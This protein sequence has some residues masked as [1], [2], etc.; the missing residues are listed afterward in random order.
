MDD[1]PHDVQPKP[2]F[3]TVRERG[4][5]VRFI[6]AFAPT[7]GLIVLVAISALWAALFTAGLLA[8]GLGVTALGVGSWIGETER[9]YTTPTHRAVIKLLI[10]LALPVT[11]AA[12][13]TQSETTGYVAFGLAAAAGLA[14]LWLFLGRRKRSAPTS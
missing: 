9:I 4:L 10:G 13:V 1:L 7:V 3:G 6:V 8:I 14:G 12:G 5:R 11:L 2:L